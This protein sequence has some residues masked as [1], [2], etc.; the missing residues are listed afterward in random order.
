VNVIC[1]DRK[2]P[3]LLFLGN[4]AGLYISLDAG[5]NWE[6]F[7]GNIPSIMVRDLTVQ[8]REN[9]LV[10]GTYGRGAWITDISPLQQFTAE[11]QKS[12][13]YLFD[14]EPKP[15][16]NYSQQAIWGNY[17]MTGSAHLR[18]S[19]E[20]NGMEIWYYF[21]SADKSTATLTVS[22]ETGKELFRKNVPHIEGIRK[23]YWDTERAIPGKYSVTLEWKGK[24]IVKDA[25]VKERWFWPVLNYR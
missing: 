2:N 7:L 20:P 8:P 24:K 22:H 25:V 12:D 4:D 16:L 14:I 11:V 18:T 6:S 3:D 5:R 15:K 23:L 9:D 13:F 21:S 19:N 10:V 1:E 17:Q